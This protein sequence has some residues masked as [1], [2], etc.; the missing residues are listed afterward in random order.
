MNREERLDDLLSMYDT[1]EK[2]LNLRLNLTLKKPKE[3]SG[4]GIHNGSPESIKELHPQMSNVEDI[5]IS[6]HRIFF[7]MMIGGGISMLAAIQLFMTPRL[8]EYFPDGSQ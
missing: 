2:W 3:K 7:A 4:F 6:M 8:A 1:P 5:A